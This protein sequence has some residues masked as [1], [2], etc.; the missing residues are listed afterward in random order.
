M[1]KF[2]FIVPV[3]NVKDYLHE[4]IESI[5]N[6]TVDNYEVIL[7]DDGSTDG[8]NIICQEY[9]LKYDKI[10]MFRKENGGLSDARNFGI[11]KAKGEYLIFVDS[12]DYIEPE[13]LTNFMHSLE[14]Y[15]NP[16]VLITRIKKIRLDT[17]KLMDS[18]LPMH[19]I[20]NNSKQDIITWMFTE[21][22]SLW[23]AVRYVV[24]REFIEEEKLKFKKGFYHEDI[25][26]TT[27][28]FL[29]AR[30]FSATDFYW[31]NHRMH[32]E[33][34]ITTVPKAKRTL[35][36]IEL[37]SNILRDSKFDRL[38]PKIRDI[39]FRRLVE[40]IYAS[41]SNYRFYNNDGK[42]NVAMYLQRNRDIL[43]HASKIK[44][45]LFNLLC[46]LFGF[47]ITLYLTYLQ[48]T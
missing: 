25:D 32:R 39:L 3:Y 23:P 8:S 30:T 36:I 17:V 14:L 34:S 28:L 48:K 22:N 40:S 13:S 27:K 2:S 5:L 7:I 45:K 15:K 4:C 33:G 38:E 47:R 26:W 9:S 12:D 37:V 16:D 18:N 24:K 1:Y 11:D 35:D 21:S 20:S 41:I 31:Y 6:Q 43:K 44:H 19:I 42:K 29:Y 10:R 46:K